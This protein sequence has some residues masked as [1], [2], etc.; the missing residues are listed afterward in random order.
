M[1]PHTR[2][3]SRSYTNDIHTVSYG[4]CP[5]WHPL[6]RPPAQG[7]LAVSIAKT[8]VTRCCNADAKPLPPRAKVGLHAPQMP[9][10]CTKCDEMYVVETGK[11]KPGGVPAENDLASF[12]DRDFAA[13]MIPHHQGAIDMCNSLLMHRCY[14]LS[15]GCPRLG[16]CKRPL[17]HRMLSLM[18]IAEH[19]A[20]C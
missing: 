19:S 11:W 3:I 2:A 18:G 16:G 20:Q 14:S 6:A 17:A 13:M 10:Q 7:T 1:S 15:L 8:F 9:F 4:G 12:G 5:L